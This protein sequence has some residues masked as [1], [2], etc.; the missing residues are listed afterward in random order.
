MSCVM[1]SGCF[2]ILTAAHC[3]ILRKCMELALEHRLTVVVALNTDDS[4]RRLKGDSRPIVPYEQRE[5]I[6][7]SLAYVDCV[8]PLDDDEPTDVIRR[9]KPTI[10][11]KGGGYTRETMPEW[12]AVES[13]GG[14]V[15]LLESFD[16]LSTTQIVEKC[17]A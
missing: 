5:T 14:R 16:G 12:D 13:G 1:T 11:V 3:E 6:L 10:Y 8:V 4:I 9:L 17:R 15:V 2:D 7:K